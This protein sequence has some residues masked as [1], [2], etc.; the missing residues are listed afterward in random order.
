MSETTL[1]RVTKTTANSLNELVRKLNPGVP[2]PGVGNLADKLL[3][4]A[5]ASV[6]SET[7]PCIG[8]EIQRLRNQ[9]HGLPPPVK[10]GDAE[11]VDQMI[12]RIM[13]EEFAARETKPTKRKA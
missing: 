4:E 2:R 1:V 3:A 12:R 11:T 9:L 8:T 6:N 7:E 5:V 13:A 10:I